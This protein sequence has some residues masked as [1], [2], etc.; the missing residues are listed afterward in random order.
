VWPGGTGSRFLAGPFLKGRMFK[1]FHLNHDSDR[2]TDLDQPDLDLLFS[3]VITILI[4]YL[5][6]INQTLIWKFQPYLDFYFPSKI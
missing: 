5:F 1:I 3:I 2:K 4:E 6:L